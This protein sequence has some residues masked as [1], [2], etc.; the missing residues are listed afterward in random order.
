MFVSPLPPAEAPLAASIAIRARPLPASRF[1]AF[2]ERWTTR[3]E[4]ARMDERMLR[5]IRLTP[6]E[7]RAEANKPFWRS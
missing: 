6:A 3:A 2:R 4:L 7:A 5:D 1:A